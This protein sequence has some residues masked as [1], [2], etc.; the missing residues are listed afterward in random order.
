MT[1]ETAIYVSEA[2]T[3]RTGHGDQSVGG[4][5]SSNTFEIRLSMYVLGVA[6][7]GIISCILCNLNGW[8]EPLKEA[9]KKLL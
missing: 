5:S 4:A 7:H 8:Y 9:G 2:Y 3:K 1:M 6:L